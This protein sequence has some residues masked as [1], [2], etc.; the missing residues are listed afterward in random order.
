ME[1]KEYKIIEIDHKGNVQEWTTWS[2]ENF[3][4]TINEDFKNKRYGT[5]FI[6]FI[7]DDYVENEL[8]NFDENWDSDDEDYKTNRDW[9]IKD[10]NAVKGSY[11]YYEGG[12][13]TYTRLGNTF[14][15]VVKSYCENIN[16]ISDKKSAKF[17]IIA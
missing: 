8:S 10:L 13:G 5:R 14:E 17:E 7:D 2:L 6:D 16:K 12:C 4:K 1:S 3:I 15:E 11:A 9:L